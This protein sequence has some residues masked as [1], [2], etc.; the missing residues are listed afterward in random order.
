[1]LERKNN[2]APAHLFQQEGETRFVG[3]YFPQ[4]LADYLKLLSAE[5][6]LSVQK[7]LQDVVY[8]QNQECST[9][10]IIQNLI[11]QA[12]DKWKDGLAQG[13]KGNREQQRLYLKEIK[14]RL[15]RRKVA[16]HHI[17]EILAQ[18]EQRIEEGKA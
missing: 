1:M 15:K 4:E 13:Q 11:Q 7:T 12:D 9:E 10:Q 14:N 17:K 5:K 18:V 2:N 6:G 8:R 3:A 16:E